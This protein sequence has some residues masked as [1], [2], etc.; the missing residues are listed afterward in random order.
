[1]NHYFNQDISWGK[2]VGRNAYAEPIFEWKEIK[3]RW[4]DKIE[5]VRDKEGREVTSVA[6]VF[7]TETVQADDVL[8]YRDK[9]WFIIAV[10]TMTKLDGSTNHLEVY[11]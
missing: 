11:L 4:Q 6:K 7:C 9:E 2:V 3:G 10:S 1:M 8:K 5:I